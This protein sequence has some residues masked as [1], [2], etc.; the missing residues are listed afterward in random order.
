MELGE[1]RRV[2]DLDG[3]RV[4][5][6]VFVDVEPSHSIAVEVGNHSA[7]VL[8]TD[9]EDAELVGSEKSEGLAD[10]RGDDAAAVGN[11]SRLIGAPLRIVKGRQVPVLRNGI[12]SLIHLPPRAVHLERKESREHGGNHLG[13]GT[14][15]FRLEDHL[16]VVHTERVAQQTRIIVDDVGL[17]RVDAFGKT[18]ID[19]TVHGEGIGLEGAKNGSGGSA[20]EN[21]FPRETVQHALSLVVDRHQTAVASA[22]L[23]CKGE[24]DSDRGAENGLGGNRV[25]GRRDDEIAHARDPTVV[26][27]EE[28]TRGKRRSDRVIK[29]SFVLGSQRLHLDAGEDGGGGGIREGRWRC[30]HGDCVE[31]ERLDSPRAAGNTEIDKLELVKCAVVD[32]EHGPFLIRQNEVKCAHSR[33]KCPLGVLG[34]LAVEVKGNGSRSRLAVGVLDLHHVHPLASI[35]VQREEN[36]IRGTGGRLD[37]GLVVQ[38]EGVGGVTGD[39]LHAS[40]KLPHVRLGLFHQPKRRI[41]QGNALSGRGVGENGDGNHVCSVVNDSGGVLTHDATRKGNGVVGQLGIGFR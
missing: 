25:L 17:E 19:V 4:G 1:E 12:C 2:V 39:G 38:V 14:H 33:Q 11:G 5:V 22:S 10:V 6:E 41:E 18:K 40:L 32:E 8:H 31:V 3:L 34:V 26:H 15:H 29:E 20:T 23:Y 28:E 13:R 36:R 27:I 16:L 35:V 37:N 9:V 30:H 21:Q 24:G 7:G